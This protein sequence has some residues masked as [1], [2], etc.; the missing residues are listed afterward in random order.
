MTATKPSTDEISHSI[1]T[2]KAFVREK[3]PALPIDEQRSLY[4]RIEQ[5]AQEARPVK[6]SVVNTGNR[7]KMK[8]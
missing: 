7:G 2:L 8:R 3:L 1:D 4:R 6:K 5:I